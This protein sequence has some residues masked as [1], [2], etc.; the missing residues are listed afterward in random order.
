MTAQAFSAQTATAIAVSGLSAGYDGVQVLHDISFTL[1]KGEA[2]A[3]LGR[4]GSGK[5]TLATALFG[6]EPQVSGQITI[7][8][9]DVT[10]WASHRI[11]RQGIALVPQGRGVFPDLTVEEN[12]DMAALWSRKQP[13]RSWTRERVFDSFPRLAERRRFHS[14]SLSGGER[15]LLAIARALLT[16]AQ[17]I[18]LDEPSEGLSPRAIEEVIIGTVGQLKSEGYTLL[19]AEQN[20]TMALQL[21]ERV[22]IL[23]HGT[24]VHDGGSAAF[25]AD[26]A[27]QRE[28]LGL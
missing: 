21:A 28:H 9:A 7:H 27:L 8:G 23:D 18:V 11:A 20:M 17:T 2:V 10:G 15:Q 14:A 19:I 25:L 13:C 4:N 12:L 26:E 24:L 16:Q 5:S 22:L 1:Q 6:M 3:L